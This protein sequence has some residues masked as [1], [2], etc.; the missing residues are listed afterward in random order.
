MF[1]S[2][3]L[4]RFAE[5]YRRHGLLATLRRLGL[6]AKR[7]LFS[8]R[9]VLFYCDLSILPTGP[10][11]LPDFLKV[12]RKRSKA[13][14]CPEDFRAITNFWNPNLARRN[15]KERFSK[16]ASLWLIK[17]N[18]GLAGYGWTLQ[19]CTVEPH[20]FPLGS[21]DVHMFDFFVPPKHRGKGINPM[22]VTS[23][24]YLL[25][26]ECAGRVFIEA[27]EWNAP[28]LASLAKTFFR[29]LGS[30]RKITVLGH[31]IVFWDKKRDVIDA[32]SAVG[33]S[34]RPTRTSPIALGGTASGERGSE[35]EAGWWATQ[36]FLQDSQSH[37]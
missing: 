7:A 2:T 18:G 15:L 24:L 37:P 9:S 8:S 33:K 21:D 31:T 23:I 6:A 34:T 1:I 25:S 27:A 4:A 36:K 5:Y 29:P 28:Q 19:G 17:S 13:E 11:K 22:L 14:I 35:T 16:G 20:Y 26:A 10:A 3:S 32:A 30:A 12:E